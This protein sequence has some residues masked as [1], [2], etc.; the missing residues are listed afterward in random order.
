M[1]KKLILNISIVAVVVFVLD[2]AI[3]RTLRYF[4]FKETS[5]QHF[6]TTCSMETT[7]ADLLVF[8]SSRANHHYVPEIFE[9]SLKTTFYNAGRD[10]NGILFQTA[11]LKSVLTR[12]FPK[13]IILDA[14]GFNK[15][16]DNYDRLSSLLPYYR[17]HKEIRSIIELKSPFE[18]IKL[19]SQIYPFNSQIIAI[20][21][22]NLD[23]FARSK[24]DNKGYVA[25]HGEWP[26]E[27]SYNDAYSAYEVDANKIFALREFINIAK[28]SGAKIFVIYSPVFLKFKKNLDIEVG[29]DVCSFENVPYWDFSR[30][31]QFLSNR[32]LFQ[33]RSHLNHKGATIFSKLIVTKIKQGILVN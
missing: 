20:A 7:E 25:L 23:F 5:G 17:T 30:D 11:V 15:E 14:G 18:K 3:G 1:I 21:T 12:Y 4:Y 22:G 19:L 6:R 24:P 9:D 16:K 33:D 8:G 26:A 31:T 28:K 10:G 29:N 2:F 13:V 27:I 32:H